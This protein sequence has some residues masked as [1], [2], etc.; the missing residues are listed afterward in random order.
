M[1]ATART[2]RWT[3]RAIAAPLAVAGGAAALVGALHLRDPHIEYSWGVCPLYAVTGLY[4]PGCGGLRAVNDVT[5]GAFGAAFASN[6]LVYPIGFLLLWVW[7]AWLGNRVG[8]RV[9]DVPRSK[10]LWIGAGVL[11]VVWTVARNLPGSPFAP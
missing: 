6:L 5:N 3:P 4:C 2:A 1:T 10:G 11:V 9:P 7:L 8:F